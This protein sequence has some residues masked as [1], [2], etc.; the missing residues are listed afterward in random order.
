MG[1]LTLKRPDPFDVDGA[2]PPASAGLRVLANNVAVGA[3]MI[4]QV[5]LAEAPGT[6]WTCP[7]AA[8][9]TVCQWTQIAG[10]GRARHC[11]TRI[12]DFTGTRGS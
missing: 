11:Y 12:M 5:C 10:G 1:A 6:W 2:S 3:L 9:E 7:V 8:P 4:V